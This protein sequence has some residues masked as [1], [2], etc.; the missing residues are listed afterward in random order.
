V[1]KYRRMSATHVA[2]LDNSDQQIHNASYKIV[3][4]ILLA[5]DISSAVK[6]TFTIDD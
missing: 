1:Y 2:I 5:S 3:I 6:N 4:F